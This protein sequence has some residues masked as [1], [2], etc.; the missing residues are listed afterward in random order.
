MYIYPVNTNNTNELKIV[1]MVIKMK[2][3]VVLGLVLSLVG[4][5]NEVTWE[6]YSDMSVE[7]QIE[8]ERE[9]NELIESAVEDL[10]TIED[11]ELYNFSPVSGFIVYIGGNYI[12]DISEVDSRLSYWKS[13][14]IRLTEYFEDRG[15]DNVTVILGIQDFDEDNRPVIGFYD[16]ENGFKEKDE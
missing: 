10:S 1:R 12:D 9:Q 3:L 8:Y 5:N 14:V 16:L 13:E 4:C 2:L 7:E 6:D 11:I 15:I